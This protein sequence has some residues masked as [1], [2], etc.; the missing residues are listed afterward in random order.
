MI[1][2][3]HQVLVLLLTTLLIYGCDVPGEDVEVITA[4]GVIVGKDLGNFQQFYGIPF[5]KP[6]VGE[7]R[8]LPTQPVTP[9]QGKRLSYWPSPW[10][11]QTVTSIDI[12]GTSEDCLYLNIWKPNTEGP[13]PVMV[14]IHGGKFLFGSA[15]QEAYNGST[16]AQDQNVVVVSINYR[17]GF[18]G[19]LTLSGSDGSNAEL[20][21]GNQGFHDQIAALQWVKQNIA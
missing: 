18:Y 12:I 10:C 11:K 1:I 15:N 14:W 6:P 5:A 16:L 19:F 2:K 3:I 8:W 17:L 13:H 21:A 4:S 7:L 20:V 9:W